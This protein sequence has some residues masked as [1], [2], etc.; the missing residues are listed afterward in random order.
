VGPGH[1]V[2]QSKLAP[3]LVIPCETKV[4]TFNVEVGMVVDKAGAAKS[5]QPAAATAN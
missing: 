4:G 1:K 5:A 2:Q 3:R